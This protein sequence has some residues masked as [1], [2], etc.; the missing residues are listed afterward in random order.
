MNGH[1]W[2]G[3]SWAYICC[4]PYWFQVHLIC[5]GVVWA[6]RSRGLRLYGLLGSLYV[7]WALQPWLAWRWWGEGL[8]V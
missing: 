3:P 1:L 8:V 2:L 5:A 4:S 6:R 7:H